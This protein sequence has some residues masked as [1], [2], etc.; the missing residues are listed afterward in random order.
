MQLGSEQLLEAVLKAVSGEGKKLLRNKAVSAGTLLL[1]GVR[2]LLILQYV[3]LINCF[4]WAMGLFTLGYCVTSRWQAGNPFEWSPVFALGVGSLA[5]STLVLFWTV[6]RRAWLRAF[7]LERQIESFIPGSHAR[8]SHTP[9]LNNSFGQL[10]EDQFAE[11][12]ERVVDRRIE[13]MAENIAE[14]IT[15]EAEEE[16]PTRHKTRSKPKPRAAS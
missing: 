5:L 10:S 9:S 7:R 2:A 3:I 16:A 8:E 14:N 11:L 1:D 13:K 12:I 15:E 4:L 6:R